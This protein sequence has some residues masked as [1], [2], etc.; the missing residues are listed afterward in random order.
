MLG[1]LKYLLWGWRERRRVREAFSEYLSPALVD[2]LARDPDAL[3][4]HGETRDV[5]VMVCGLQGFVTISE[6]LKDELQTLSALHNGFLTPMT[7]RILQNGGTIDRFMGGRILAF[8][9]AP[10]ET[11]GHPA[12]A[13]R[14]ALA[15]RGALSEL[16]ADPPDLG[17][18]AS[19]L[20]PLRFSIGLDTGPCAVGNFG[21][22]QR[23]D[24]S[25][26]G[27]PVSRAERLEVL[28]SEYDV[29]ILVTDAVRRA[30]PDFAVSELGRISAGQ[31]EQD[32]VPLFALLG[33][34]GER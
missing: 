25:A 1:R 3:K 22:E 28:A 15:M 34:A 12:A 5:T 23:F 27:E 14:A 18:I 24:Y 31:T 19:Q 17:P 16:N 11:E 2:Q 30:A 9:N 33:E 8:W 21:S 20:L 7:D 13:C 32:T 26:Y 29:D 10:I 6:R 4:L